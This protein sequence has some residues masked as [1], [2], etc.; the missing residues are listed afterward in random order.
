MTYTSEVLVEPIEI[1]VDGTALRNLDN[2]VMISVRRGFDTAA[3]AHIEID[4]TRDTSRIASQFVV[5]KHLTVSFGKLKAIAVTE[6]FRGVI[7]GVGTEFDMERTQLQV[8]A[9]DESYAL[10]RAT[11]VATHVDKTYGD[12][13]S[14]IAGEFGLSPSISGL[15]TTKFEHVQQFGTPHQFLDRITRA[16]GCE[17]FVTGTTLT[18]QPRTT[19]VGAEVKLEG[20]VNLMAFSARY[21][22]SE[23][24]ASLTVRGWDPANQAALVGTAAAPTAAATAPAVDK[25]REKVPRKPATAWPRTPL[26]QNDATAIATGMRQ[27]MDDT[28]ITGRGQTYVNPDIVPGVKVTIDG[29]EPDWN[30]SY[31]VADVEHILRRASGYITRFTIGASEPTSLVD[32]LGNSAPPSSHQ[33]LG[34][35]TI[36]TVTNIE[37]PE[38]ERRVKLKLPYLSSDEDSGWA[39]VVQLGA[40]SER[41]LWIHP[42]VGDEVIVAFEQGDARR[43]VVI[44]G[45]WSA[46]N[47]APATAVVNGG[48]LVGRSLTSNKGHLLHFDDSDTPLIEIKHATTTAHVV[49]HKDNGILV[50]APD[51]DVVLK[52]KQG[53]IKIAKSTGDITMETQGKLTIKATQDVTI[54][55]MNVNVKSS[56]NTKVEAGAMLEAKASAMAK[57]DGGT[58]TEIKGAMVKIN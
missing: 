48:E 25:N 42:E 41:G 9:Y 26:D 31:R 21:S 53:S 8:D 5:G 20:G 14:A 52:N 54:E 16:S 39:R 56:A 58:M 12:I 46:R 7:L 10:G 29:V 6:V 24:A 44:G 45:V 4:T 32:L 22:A 40:G 36:G 18:V 37:D 19:A 43:P 35:V 1:K 34:G 50:E 47:A 15:P 49:L 17:W 27:W 2:V 3:H 51:H 11:V 57:I 30:G 23:E 13:V 38:N 33:F 55:G 28:S